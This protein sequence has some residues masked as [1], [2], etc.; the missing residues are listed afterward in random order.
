MHL[1][2][3]KQNLPSRPGAGILK[4]EFCRNRCAFPLSLTTVLS[5][6]PY[7]IRW[8]RR[9]SMIQFSNRQDVVAVVATQ[10]MVDQTLA[11]AVPSA[12]VFVFRLRNDMLDDAKPA[13]EI[14]STGLESD[15]VDAE[16]LVKDTNL[17]PIVRLVNLI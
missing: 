5:V 15:L 7:L 11:P 14:E 12:I 2:S 6:W 10:T 17:P 13:G 16:A 3:W 8:P 1:E 4:P 9:F